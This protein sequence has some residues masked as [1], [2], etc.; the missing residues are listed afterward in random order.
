MEGDES[1][2]V[3]GQ[4]AC[5]DHDTIIENVSSKGADIEEEEESERESKRFSDRAKS[6]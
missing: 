1:L 5:E 3:A 6:G 2:H 4:P